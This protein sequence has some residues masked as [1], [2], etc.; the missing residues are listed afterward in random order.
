MNEGS[1]TVAIIPA[2][3][4]SKGLPGKNLLE[5]NGLPLI[6]WSISFALESQ[7]FSRV[8]VSTDCPEIARVATTFGATVLDLRPAEL[9]SDEALLQDVILFELET[10][11]R[12]SKL[13]PDYIVVLQPTSP[14]RRLTDL[15]QVLSLLQSDLDNQSVVSVGEF[16]IHPSAIKRARG[17]T[18]VPYCKDLQVIQRRQEGVPALLPTG[19]YFGLD[20]PAFR[21]TRRIYTGHDSFLVTPD[22]CNV[23]IDSELDLFLTRAILEW[24]GADGIFRP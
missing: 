22:Y 7:R 3:S 21:R 17:R 4:G 2:R 20:V 9:A 24:G 12:R 6:G 23:D 18:L 19:A 14:L 10:M 5:L 13:Y 15:H 11:R 16:N 1:D 8:I